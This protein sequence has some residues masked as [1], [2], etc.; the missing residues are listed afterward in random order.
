MPS[1]LVLQPS[2]SA[3]WVT[4]ALRRSPPCCRSLSDPGADSSPSTQIA[5]V[6]KPCTSLR[7]IRD[8]EEKDSAFRGICIMIGV[9]PGGVVQDFIFFCDAVASWVSPKDDLRDMF[10][11]ILHGFK[12]QVGEENWQQFSEQFPPLLKER[13][14]AC[15]GV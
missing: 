6:R 5:A 14:A 10:Y 9:N 12:E 4:F 3:D 13:L 7:N 8:N 11:K 1:M 15:Y 2:P